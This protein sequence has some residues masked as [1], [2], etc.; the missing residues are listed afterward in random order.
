MTLTDISLRDNFGQAGFVARLQ[1]GE[2]VTLSRT[3]PP[4]ATSTRLEVVATS[5]GEEICRAEA[6][7]QVGLPGEG[8]SIPD[9]DFER[10][11]P[12]DDRRLRTMSTS[13]EIELAVGADPPAVR[14]GERTTVRMTVTNRG[15][16]PLRGV[17]INGPGFA[18]E[19]GDLSPG[20]SKTFSRT[21]TIA[22]DLSAEVVAAGTTDAGEKASDKRSLMVAAKSSDLS[23][24]VISDPGSS[25]QPATTEY[26]IAN[27][28]EEFLS[29]VTLKDG[30]GATLGILARLG[31]GESK[32]LTRTSLR[33]EDPRGPIEVS[34]V[35]SGGRTVTGDVIL[36]PAA[37]S[38]ETDP[39]RKTTR[40]GSSS[41]P[42]PGFVPN[43][44]EMAFEL[45]FDE[46]DAGFDL[47][48]ARSEGGD[49]RSSRPR[50]Q[51]SGYDPLFDAGFDFADLHLFTG[52]P[53][54]SAVGSGEAVAPPA[55][56]ERETGSPKLVVTL[57]VNRTRVHQGDTV[58][59]R[60]VAVNR[61]TASLFDL[62]LRCG[63]ETA[64]A[65]RL[66][67]G[68]GLPL[69][70][71]VIADGNLNL[72]AAARGRGEGGPELSDEATLD[73]VA[74][75]PDLKVE[76]YKE[77]EKI[78]RGERISIT[79]RLENVG[80]DPLS[81]VRVSDEIGEIGR[82]PVL[83]PGE[84]RLL[85][86]NTTLDESLEDVVR[87]E[88]IDSAGFRLQR[89][90]VL[91]LQLLAPGLHLTVDPGE[92]ATYPGEAAEVVWTIRNSGEVDLLDV[93]FEVEGMSRFRLPAVPA[94]GSMPVSTVH[95]AEESRQ[96]MGRAE[97]RTAGGETVF[98]TEALKI[99]V[100]SPGI[101][102]SVKPSGVEA[103]QKRPFNLTFVVTNTGDDVLRDV[104]LLEKS[105]GTLERIG[106]LEAGDFKVV[107]IDFLAEKNTTFRLEAAGTDSR[108]E[109]WRDSREVGVKIVSASI[110]L[111]VRAE[112]AQIA[113]GGTVEVVSTV[114]NRGDSPIFS[115][116]I[117][118]SSLEHL[119]TIDYISP[120]S[121]RTVVKRIEASSDIE[122]EIT[123][124]GFTRERTSVRDTDV[125][126]VVVKEPETYPRKDHPRE[127][128]DPSAP[129]VSGRGSAGSVPVEELVEESA[130]YEGR[131][132]RRDDPALREDGGYGVAGL[133]NRLREILEEFRMKKDGSKAGSSIKDGFPE[134]SQAGYASAG[135]RERGLYPTPA[136]GPLYA[137][138][139]GERV[140]P[141]L[142]PGSALPEGARYAPSMGETL[143]SSASGKTVP[144][145]SGYTYSPVESASGKETGALGHPS[146]IGGM[147]SS[148]L[149]S[150]GRSPERPPGSGGYTY[151]SSAPAISYL[152]SPS[153]IPGGG[154]SYASASG[155][156]FSSLS[157][158]AGISPAITGPSTPV[159]RESADPRSAL[160]ASAKVAEPE[161]VLG[162]PGGQIS[163]QVSPGY[164]GASAPAGT[165]AQERA[166]LSRSPAKNIRLK[167]GD[168]GTIE[169]DRPPKI[170]DVGAFPPDPTAWTPVMV[171]VHAT[172]DIG[173]RS[174]D[175]LWNIPSA[176]VS[177]M[178]LG[179]INRI[180]SQKMKLED[181]DAREGYWSYEIPG[182]APGTYM[183][184]FV[185][186]SDG[187]R[188]A[189]DGPY[190][191]FWSSKP[192]EEGP[193]KVPSQERGPLVQDD[194][195]T[196]SARGEKTTEMRGDGMLFVE[197][198]TVIGRGD[199][200]I[201]NEFRE[202]SA[203]YRE[204]L[205]GSGSIEMQSDK[206][207]NRG[208]P[209]V[210]ITD[211][212]VLVFDQGVLKGSKLMQSPGFHGGM[213][214]S[215]LER[216]N[217]TTL[218]KRETGTISSVNRADNVL[219]FN[220]QQAF[221]GIWGTRTEY[222]SFNKR[223]KADQRLSGTFETQRRITFED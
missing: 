44:E 184:V 19:A 199:V 23:V 71:A 22:G 111:T 208:N 190:I 112:P 1:E 182:Q 212:R 109:V 129:A 55:G 197:S 105:L 218:E 127:E 116:F 181:G 114:E 12:I 169:I 128:P 193:R 186:V 82:I 56:R 161:G 131:E 76:V 174:V 219:L 58:G 48:G 115:T 13:A 160:E 137:P 118:T 132:V 32:S 51:G 14:P 96:V 21:L 196:A 46:I 18:V 64:T 26:R 153:A 155:D 29:R 149:S 124:E 175:M 92:V 139:G 2:A 25:G 183:A 206:K 157:S 80:D 87:V 148:Y 192:P 100:V 81:E 200:S 133:L 150:P 141:P 43:F 135:V 167:V 90:M 60:A 209:V 102:L 45:S 130:G 122:E 49:V 140:D 215:V 57:Q 65:P 170:I 120:G 86:R 99:R 138:Q 195:P 151:S 101:G 24:T 31:A 171:V 185:R 39:S 73:I 11:I 94:G 75:S 5:G 34:A 189:E 84:V 63:D 173:V 166:T 210:N 8:I 159:G 146:S 6:R 198:T 144:G 142:S 217:A 35:S 123:A 103:S 104:T 145:A 38:P 188:W 16:P 191:L 202:S 180:N 162:I 168:I 117:M 213:G 27:S 69:E 126:R 107:T 220:T 83:R 165:P 164:A 187:E 113:P 93:T 222:S 54:P 61:G 66:A 36:R 221:E 77:P 176:T 89:S 47:F 40:S 143:A 88:A 156:P 110:S 134:G 91:T 211:S 67:P 216:F 53:T 205:D 33:G 154:A 41:A 59:Y 125:L 20:E 17:E 147:A 68:D 194:L 62:E 201:K 223:I 3:T 121:S 207:I 9:L 37:T 72:T 74:I 106:R 78:S 15:Q 158:P 163:A 70:G 50:P 152:S 28:G 108:G 203:L 42:S 136:Q 98:A 204:V 178:D 214:A 10:S 97:G 30:D 52:L 177:R 85:T 4:L 119:G 7:L 79:V 179:D 172:D 95:L